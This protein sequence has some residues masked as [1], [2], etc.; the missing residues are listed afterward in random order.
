M[1]YFRFDTRLA[2]LVLG[3]A[4][5][6]MRMQGVKIKGAQ[7]G[8]ALSGLAFL[9]CLYWMPGMEHNTYLTT[10]AEIFAFFLLGHILEVKDWVISGW[11]S[12]KIPVFFGRIS[13]AIY[14]FHFPV[15]AL[16]FRA[17]EVRPGHDHAHWSINLEVTFALSVALA[18]FSW[19]TVEKAGRLKGR[20]FRRKAALKHAREE[21]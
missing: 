14:L 2:G 13:Y 15:A 11:L 10:V 21:G 8:L 7:A 20:D 5:A 16:L 1:V 18:W 17:S 19:K 12:Q 9:F 6:A 4:L 3:A